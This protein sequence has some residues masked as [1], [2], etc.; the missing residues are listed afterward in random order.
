VNEVANPPHTRPVAFKAGALEYGY[1]A[2]LVIAIG[3]AG[4]LIPGVG[5]LPL[6]K[7]ALALPLLLALLRRKQL[8]VLSNDAKPAAK[9][10]LWL[11]AIALVLTPFSVWKGASFAFLYQ[12]LPVLAAT[13]FLAHALSRS[14]ATVRGTLVALVL[15]GLILARAALSAYGGGRAA[16]NTMYDTNDLAYL[17]VTV[18]PLSIGFLITSKTKLRWLMNAGISA[19]LLGALLLTQSR[20]GLLGLVAVLM[21][22]IFAPI[23]PRESGNLKKGPNRLVLLLGVI[24]VGFVVWS[25]LPADARARFATMLDLGNDYNLDPNDVT[26]RGQIWTRGLHAALARPVG[27]APRTF[28][29]VEWRLGGQFYAPHNSFVQAM[30]E[31]GFLGVVLF[32]RMYFLS[33]RGLRRARTVLLSSPSLT[34]DQRD[35][36]VFA[37]I[38][39]IALVG[40]FVAGFFLSMA[41]ATLVWTFFGVSMAMMSAVSREASPHA[42]GGLDQ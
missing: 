31:L 41:Y 12:E 39:Q 16:T 3:R 13:V 6:G 11:A 14:W 5:A 30:V 40:N 42:R 20:G 21:F 38:L 24:L 18:F 29:M 2:F 36:A 9:N 17:L 34:S 37:R 35:Q 1:W 4:E 26:S 10:A 22:L 32:V 7:L 15:S 27:Y 23:R 25:Q 8:P 33:W 19:I 28:N